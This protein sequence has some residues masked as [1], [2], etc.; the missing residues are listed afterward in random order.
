LAIL[1]VQL[2]PQLIAWPS[3]SIDR[4]AAAVRAEAYL[5]ERGIE[6]NDQWRRSITTTHTGIEQD[7]FVQQHGGTEQVNQ[8]LELGY[9]NT[10][11]WVI[12]WRRFEGP[13]EARAES[14]SAWLYP[15]GRL[16]ELVH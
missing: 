2:A 8:L 6:L 1:W 14:W 12:N 9:L 10:S 11:Y 7:R 16:H 15:D 13:V 5:N 3:F 4:E